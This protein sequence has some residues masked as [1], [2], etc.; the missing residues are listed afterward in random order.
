M[1]PR[2]AALAA[3]LCAS[4]ALAAPAEVLAAAAAL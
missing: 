1:K 4:E 3:G 2:N